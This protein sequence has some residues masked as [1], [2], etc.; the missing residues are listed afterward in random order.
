MS[1]HA[2][3]DWGHVR[4]ALPSGMALEIMAC[5]AIIHLT[6]Q[7]DDCP[8]SLLFPNF[9]ARTSPLKQKRTRWMTLRNTHKGT[10]PS[11]PCPLLKAITLVLMLFPSS[12]NHSISLGPV[13]PYGV[14]PTAVQEHVILCTLHRW[15]LTPTSA[16]DVTNYMVPNAGT[17]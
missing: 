8:L 6:N 1:I 13:M 9:L 4:G 16:F 15:A 2:E 5:I 11:Y 10:V 17:V 12:S 14:Q 7:K 3:T